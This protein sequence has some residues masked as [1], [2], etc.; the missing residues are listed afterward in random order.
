VKERRTEQ[1]AT[2]ILDDALQQLRE[3]RG[4]AQSA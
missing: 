4:T 1:E 3:R 2:Q